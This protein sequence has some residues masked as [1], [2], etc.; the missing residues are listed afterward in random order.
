MSDKQTKS[1]AASSSLYRNLDGWSG[2]LTRMTFIAMPLVGCFFVMDIPFYFEWAVLRE[3]YYGL[4][5]AMILPCTFILVPMTKTAPRDRIPWYDLILALLGVVIGLYIAIF[6]Q[7]IA[8]SLGTITP[9]RVILGTI[10]LALIVEASR[11]VTNWIL[12]GFGLLF[13]LF[14]HFAWMLSD[15]FSGMNIPFPQQVNYLF[16]ETNGMLS[17]I[18]GVAAIIVLAFVLFGNLMFS[19]GGGA[20][21]TDIAM[22]CFGRYRGGPAKIAVVA[23]TLFGTISGVVVA[24]VATTGVVTIPLMK[25]IGYKPHLA[26]AIESVASTGGQLC[27]PIMGVTAFV[28][29][30]LLGVPYRQVAIAALI[31]ALLYYAAIFFQVDMEAG[32]GGMK[33]LPQEQLPKIAGVLNKSYLFIIPFGALIAALFLLY[34][35]P[36]K[37]ALVGVL[38][39]LVVGLLI[40]KETRFRLGW[41][42]EGL[43]QTGRALLLICPVAALAGI[44]VGTISYTGIG[45]LI[46]LNLAKVAGGNIFVLMPIIALACFILGMGMPTLT[47]YIVLAVLMGP[48]M[49][50]LGV[51][52]M[53]AHMFILYYAGLSM[54]TPPVCIAAYAG[55]AIAGSEPMRTGLAAARLGIISY[56]V[57]FLFVF[58]PALLFIGSWGEILVA[59][60]TA[61]SGCFVLSAALV[62]YLFSRL[63][64]IKRIL[65]GLAG[66]ALLIPIRSHAD[67]LS[68]SVNIGGFGVAFLLTLSEWNRRRER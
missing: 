12:A 27:P 42:L 51:V 26:G 7:Q 65:F 9:D 2:R 48:V 29:A 32:K 66:L 58:F 6:Y 56:I 23:S 21:I 53:A 45:F 28:M 1:P 30:E 46:S 34:L 25:K 39:I 68:L 60:A 31:P 55:A 22:A 8:L 3:Q 40:Q 37:S 57:P 16:L 52:P 10:G 49:V 4:I 67:V 63:G 20:F 64:P 5:L 61:M 17:M 41:I 15:F 18:F 14:P 35:S 19:I 13:I 59:F 47:A 36:E 54:I 43:S 11:R 38:S 33:G 44:V 50:E 62:G 24:N